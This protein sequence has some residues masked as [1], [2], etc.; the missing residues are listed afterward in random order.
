MEIKEI[1]SLDKSKDRK[2]ELR[3]FRKIVF[4]FYYNIERIEEGIL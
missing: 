3:N 4:L 1:E 2:I